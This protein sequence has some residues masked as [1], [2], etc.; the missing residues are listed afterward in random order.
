M[1]RGSLARC[2]ERWRAAGLSEEEAYALAADATVGAP[3]PRLRGLLQ[4]RVSVLVGEVGAG[5]SLTLDRLF[6]RCIV[7]L[8]EDPDTPLPAFVEAWEVGGRL[9]DEVVRKTSTLDNPR[10]RG[11]AIFVDG[12]EEAG[13]GQAARLLRESRILANTWPNTTVM[14]AGRPIWELDRANE[15]IE[16]PALTS[17][18][19]KALIERVSGQELRVAVTYGWPSSVKEAVKRPL[20][21]ILVGVNLRDRKFGN[22]RSTGE[23]LSG[24]VD[25]ALEGADE[26]VELEQ[27]RHLAVA[28]VDQGGGPVRAADVATTAEVRR[29]RGTGLVFERSGAVGFSLQ[30]LNEWFAAQALETGLVDTR[31]LAS[32][33]ARLERWRYPLMIAV[34]TFGFQR[35]K[36]MIDPIVI[37]AAPAFASQVVQEGLVGRG[38]SEDVP[39]PP[40]S[41]AVGSCAQR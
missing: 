8:R 26:E 39:P 33:P 22:P 19:T 23:L 14:I 10:R 38:L 28:S 36:N 35:V 1:E 25:K 15:K 32:D 21:A 29:L 12:V 7:R 37:R 17:E 5:K 30:I 6:Q 18:E 41:S 13:R 34:G 16:V 4:R 11:A 31:N 2:A 9:E 27:L 40:P 3:G 24:L 20:F